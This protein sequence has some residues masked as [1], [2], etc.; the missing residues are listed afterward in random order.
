MWQTIIGAAAITFTIRSLPSWSTNLRKILQNSRINRLLDYT[1]CF[2]TGE[3]IYSLIESHLE[4]NQAIG[5]S[6]SIFFLVAVLTLL[7]SAI[8]TRY[9][10]KLGRSFA[11]GLCAFV[12]LYMAFLGQS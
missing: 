2:I 7:V 1:V 12:L 11:A 6:N 5:N 9:T 4:E 10:E 8:V 3:L